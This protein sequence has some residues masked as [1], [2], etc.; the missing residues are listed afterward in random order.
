MIYRVWD[1]MINRCYN[2]NDKDFC[3][4]G[5]IGI[6]VSNEWLNFS[7]FISDVKK[8][9]NYYNKLLF[10]SKYTF[11]KDLLQINIPKSKRIYSFKTCIWLEKEINVKIMTIERNISNKK[12]NDYNKN[13]Y[14]IINKDIILASRISLE[15]LL[16]RTAIDINIYL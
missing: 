16:K 6:K 3:Y 7:N 10:P 9:R 4:Y 5:N 1:D 8:I 15:K 12:F 11:D 2:K 14:D 13:I